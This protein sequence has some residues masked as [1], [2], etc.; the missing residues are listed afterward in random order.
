[1]IVTDHLVRPT[2]AGIRLNRNG[3]EQPR[4]RRLFGLSAHKVCPAPPV[5]RRAVGSY[6]TISP[7]PDLMSELVNE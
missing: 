1:M 3:D 7:L 5:A 4:I 6:P 2:R